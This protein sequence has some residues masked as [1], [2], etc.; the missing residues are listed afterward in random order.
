[1][2]HIKTQTSTKA[3]SVSL[4]INKGILPS[5]IELDTSV[6]S[7]HSSFYIGGSNVEHVSVVR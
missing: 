1:M 4:E 6:G 7:S 3:I 5:G 2:N